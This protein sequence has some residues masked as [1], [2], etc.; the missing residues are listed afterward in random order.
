L[1]NLPFLNAT[2]T[3]AF[4]FI[5]TDAD[6]PDVYIV[7]SS[8]NAWSDDNV[9]FA[10]NSSELKKN[11]ATLNLLS[12]NSSSSTYTETLFGQNYNWTKAMNMN[13]SWN[14]TFS[15]VDLVGHSNATSMIV[16]ISSYSNTTSTP[17][18]ITNVLIDD[19][20]VQT[21]AEFNIT[22]SSGSVGYG[23]NLS[24]NF[25]V[26]FADDNS[27]LIN[28][29][30]FNGS[31]V[32][33]NYVSPGE[34]GMNWT[35]TFNKSMNYTYFINY[36]IDDV[37]TTEYENSGGCALSS[38]LRYVLISENESGIIFNPTNVKFRLPVRMTW[39]NATD[40]VVQFLQC[41]NNTA[42]ICSGSW[43]DVSTTLSRTN[44][45]NATSG[46]YEYV[47]FVIP[48]IS[49]QVLYKTNIIPRPVVVPIVYGGTG[50]SLSSYS[51][52][53]S[54]APITPGL[55]DAISEWFA[56]PLTYVLGFA[57]SPFI[58]AMLLAGVGVYANRDKIGNGVRR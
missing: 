37:Y 3:S 18:H 35:D 48:T 49:G 4:L 25:A 11:Y 1:S 6:I 52:S 56:T 23:Q 58:I 47:D 57:I 2:N 33:L 28:A 5:Y 38:C 32:F 43:N 22:C 9:Y 17:V 31:N 46:V 41:S 7:N 19:A 51:S 20:Q 15:V 55:L 42:L 39:D 50:S 36:T 44:V 53:T 26:S 21:S 10:I 30:R 8:S 14:L 24:R 34:K 54:N 27:T 13:G 29:T 12:P 40:Y 16:N 45:F